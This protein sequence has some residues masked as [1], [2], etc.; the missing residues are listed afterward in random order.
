MHLLKLILKAPV[1]FI[2]FITNYISLKREGV[3]YNGYPLIYGT[4]VLKNNGYCQLGSNLIFRNT[5]ASNYIGLTKKCSLFIKENGKLVIGNNVGLSG[6]TICATK[7]ITIGNYVNFGGNASIWDTDFHPLD[8]EDRRLHN[9]NRIKA[10]PVVIGNDVFIGANVMILKGVTIGDRSIVGAGSVVTKS[11]PE[12]EIWAGNP[13]CFIKKIEA[14]NKLI[15][16]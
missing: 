15:A 14:Q 5:S 2:N 16:V 11:I 8:F 6:T 4:I 7:S 9:E 10:I 12:D 13:A 3:I 1:R